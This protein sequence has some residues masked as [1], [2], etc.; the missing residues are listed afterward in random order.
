[1]IKVINYCLLVK[2]FV[3]L[4][5]AC[6]RYLSLFSIISDN[7]LLVYTLFLNSIFKIRTSALSIPKKLATISSVYFIP[8]TYP[9]S[10]K[11]INNLSYDISVI[12]SL[13]GYIL[14]RFNNISNVLELTLLLGSILLWGYSLSKISV[15]LGNISL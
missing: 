13:K 5:F 3:E 6:S 4:S 12:N 2:L 10:N 11:P 7:K 9:D 14:N 1:M 8:S 15:I